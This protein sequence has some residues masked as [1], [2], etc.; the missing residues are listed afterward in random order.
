MILRIQ[1][2]DQELRFEKRKG[3]PYWRRTVF[4][5]THVQIDEEVRNVEAV[6]E[7]LT[8]VGGIIHGYIPAAF[9]NRTQRY[10]GPAVRKS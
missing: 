8:A 5:G 4:E 3:A 2:L 9:R 6:G 1:D 10:A 7:I